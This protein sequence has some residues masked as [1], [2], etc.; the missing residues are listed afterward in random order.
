MNRWL[1]AHLLPEKA[2]L[3]SASRVCGA[4]TIRL[5]L[6]YLLDV[7]WICISCSLLLCQQGSRIKQCI[8]LWPCDPA[9]TRPGRLFGISN[10]EPLR[11]ARKF[12]KPI[13]PIA[14]TLEIW[15]GAYVS[16]AT[17][18]EAHEPGTL[19]CL[20]LC[21]GDTEHAVVTMRCRRARMR[22]MS[23]GS[24]IS[25]TSAGFHYVVSSNE[26][27]RSFAC[28]C[29]LRLEQFLSKRC[30]KL[31]DV[32]QPSSRLLHSTRV[33]R[34]TTVEHD[35]ERGGGMRKTD[36]TPSMEK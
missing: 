12:G 3:Y 30:L 29:S 16:G 24:A 18:T 28:S 14:F 5:A 25:S 9:D 17:S 2:I 32:G 26:K 22:H 11:S 4:C 34:T 21:R 35:Q 15:I 20:R 33:L 1:F 36:F 23:T 19:D 6:F 10:A 27:G 13:N 31:Q 8:T 7:R